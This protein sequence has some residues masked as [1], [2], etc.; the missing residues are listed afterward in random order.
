MISLS[1]LSVYVLLNI[2]LLLSERES[3]NNIQKKRHI[4]PLKL[5]L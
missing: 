1:L 3:N 5:A 4:L 2:K